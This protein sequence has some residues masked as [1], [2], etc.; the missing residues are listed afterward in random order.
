M[1]IHINLLAEAQEAEDLRR[2]DPVKR[3]IFFGA[4]LAVFML[5]WSGTVWVNAKLANA[6]LAGVQ[7]AIDEHNGDYT[8]VLANINKIA[9]ARSKLDALQKLQSARFLQG[10]LLN[11]L[12]LTTVDGVQLTRLRVDQ[13]YFLTPG[14]DSKTDGGQVIPGRP[15]TVTERVDLTLEA[16][17]FS[18]NPGDQ[19]NKLKQAIADQSYF[20]AILD[21]TNSVQLT[22]QPVLQTDA[23]GKSFELFTLECHF[24][25]QSR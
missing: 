21:N 5:V 13:S 9:V 16:K 10:N 1:P 20:K 22:S 15:P 23:D 11:A 7:A 19:V 8:N 2:R 14:T 24:P 4:A 17:D 25:E 18:A 6:T 3:A 12:Q